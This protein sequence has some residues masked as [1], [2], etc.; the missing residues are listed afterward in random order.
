MVGARLGHHSFCRIEQPVARGPQRNGLTEVLYSDECRRALCANDPLGSGQGG[1]PYRPD[2][3]QAIS[4]S[5]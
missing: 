4:L 5:G 1:K 2:G 3:P